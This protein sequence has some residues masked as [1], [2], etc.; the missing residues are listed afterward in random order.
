MLIS[1]LMMAPL[2]IIFLVVVG[3]FIIDDPKA[4]GEYSQAILC[5]LL[6]LAILVMFLVGL[7]R[8]IG[9]DKPSTST[10]TAE[11]HQVESNH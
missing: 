1:I 9:L 5:I 11:S 2:T 7:T 10:T 6:G 4:A 3:A 8:I